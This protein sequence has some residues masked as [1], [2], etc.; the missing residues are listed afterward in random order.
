MPKKRK[1]RA[2]PK[3]YISLGSWSAGDIY[4]GVNDLVEIRNPALA[5]RL[6]EKKLIR[7]LGVIRG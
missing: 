4:A 5:A 2:K 7:D 1:S 3:K 6:K